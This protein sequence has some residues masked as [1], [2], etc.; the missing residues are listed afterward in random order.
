MKEDLKQLDEVVVIGYG[1]AKSKDLTAPIVSV[2][3]NELAKQVASNP[4]QAL[5]GKVAGVQII[6]SGKPGGESTVKIRGVGSIGDYAKPLYVVDGVFVDNID[7]LSSNDIESLTVL[8]DA[9]AAAIYGV[10][11]A[12]GVILVTTRKGLNPTPAINYDGYVGLQVPVNIMP[13][14]TKDQYITLYNEANVNTTGFVP[15]NAANYPASTDWYQELVRKAMTHSHNLDVSGATD[16]TSY[17]FGTNYFYQQGI[18][19]AKNDYERVNLRTRID[20]KINNYVKV[21]FNTVYSNYNKQIPNDGTAFFG[22]YVNPP[23][24]APYDTNNTD[25]YPVK[26]GSPQMWG[27]GNQYGNPLLLLITTIILKKATSFVE[28]QHRTEFNP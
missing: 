3:G 28:C 8:K 5:Q 2:K 26:F 11:A 23:V 18:M 20:Q 27:Y 10:R 7:F 4:M 22:A 13:M 17:S 9:S 15:K 12:N 14:A 19:D 6:N 1:S 16:K 24:Y 21:G 25:A